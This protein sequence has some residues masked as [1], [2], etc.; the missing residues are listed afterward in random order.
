MADTKRKSWID[1]ARGICAFC[2]LLAHTT[3]RQDISSIYNGFFLMLFFFISGYLHKERTLKDSF[4]NIFS[5]L[6]I[7]YFSFSILLN[8]FYSGETARLLFHGDIDFIIATLTKTL[9]GK[10]L[11]FLPCLVCVRVLFVFIQYLSKKVKIWNSYSVFLFAFLF[12]LSVYL[13]VEHPSD[14]PPFWY[15]TTAIYSFGF[16]TFGHF[17]RISKLAEKVENS[18]KCYAGILLVIYFLASYLIQAYF[19][20]EFHVFQDFFK[21]PLV[22]ILLAVTGIFIVC[23]FAIAFGEYHFF[24]NKYF[25]LLGNNTLLLFAIN[26]KVRSLLFKVLSLLHIQDNCS[27]SYIILICIMQGIVV[28]CVGHVFNKYIPWIVGKHK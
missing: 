9:T 14:N 4:F 18:N 12:I 16:Y 2:V 19:D 25:I 28:V 17:C 8:L 20:V 23:Y 5:S 21:S 1:F 10:S 27:F 7:P 6:I 11:W 15:W 26:G 13:V 22:F 3:Y 24:I